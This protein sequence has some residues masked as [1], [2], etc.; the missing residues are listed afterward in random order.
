MAWFFQEGEEAR[1]QVVIVGIGAYGHLK[2]NRPGYQAFATTATILL[3]VV[4]LLWLYV[5][6]MVGNILSFGFGE[7]K[8]TIV[9]LD[10]DNVHAPVGPLQFDNISM[11]YLLLAVASLI[12]AGYS[13]TRLEDRIVLFVVAVIGLPALFWGGL[14]GFVVGLDTLSMLW[15]ENKEFFPVDMHAPAIIA[16]SSIVYLLS[17]CVGVYASILLVRLWQP[18]PEPHRQEPPLPLFPSSPQNPWG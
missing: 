16:G 11:L 10:F 14:T 3:I 8:T 6:F 2:K 17:C 4:Q 15:I 5:A 1:G 9:P 12:Y 18:S 7:R 13:E